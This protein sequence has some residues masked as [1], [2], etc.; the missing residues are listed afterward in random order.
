M[1]LR[2]YTI[3]I[4]RTGLDPRS[5]NVGLVVDEVERGQ[6]FFEYSG[7]PYQFSFHRLLHTHLSSGAGAIGPR[8]A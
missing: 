2:E 6:V 3:F 1:T 5:G 4:L 8:V 7:F